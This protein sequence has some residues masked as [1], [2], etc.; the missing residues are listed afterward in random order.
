MGRGRRRRTNCLVPDVDAKLRY[1]DR[2]TIKKKG[3]DKV[4]TFLLIKITPYP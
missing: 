1:S 2:V 3:H 4:V